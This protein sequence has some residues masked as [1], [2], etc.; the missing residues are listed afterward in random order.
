MSEQD[1]NRAAGV[2]EAGGW[3]SRAAK[4]AAALDRAV[5]S[6]VADTP[7]PSLDRAL[8]QLS[9]AADYSRLSIASAAVLSVTEG[10]GAAPRLAWDWPR[11]R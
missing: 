11:W 6:A 10:T 2:E 9:R 4:E 3:G 1:A 7:T 5:Y 8:S